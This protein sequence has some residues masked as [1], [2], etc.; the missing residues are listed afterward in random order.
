MVALCGVGVWPSWGSG[1][2]GAI[3]I[4]GQTSGT[5]AHGMGVLSGSSWRLAVLGTRC[6]GAQWIS[7]LWGQGEQCATDGLSAARCRLGAL[8]LSLSVFGAELLGVGLMRGALASSASGRS[9]AVFAYWLLGRIVGSQ[10]AWHLVGRLAVLGSC[11]RARR[12]LE[13]VGRA[14]RGL[15]RRD[16]GRYRSVRAHAL[17]ARSARSIGRIGRFAPLAVLFAF[18]AT[19]SS[20]PHSRSL[21]LGSSWAGSAFAFG[22]SSA[23]E[24]APSALGPLRIEFAAFVSC[25]GALRVLAFERLSLRPLMGQRRVGASQGVPLRADSLRSGAPSSGSVRAAHCSVF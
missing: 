1:W 16:S 21:L 25:I 23:F 11:R 22:R 12:R 8:F 18:A 20:G 9:G 13:C 14:V 4:L 7:A 10:C 17:L 2:M 3:G 5:L 19:A 6:V 15:E 24:F